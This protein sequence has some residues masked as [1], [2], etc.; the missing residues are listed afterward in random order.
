MP[1]YK[2]L[3]PVTFTGT[4][5]IQVPDNFAG[6]CHVNMSEPPSPVEQG[7][8]SVNMSGAPAGAS[9]TLR[10]DANVVVMTGTESTSPS[11]I[12]LGTYTLTWED[13]A[14]AYSPPGTETHTFVDDTPY[15]FGPP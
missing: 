2:V 15:T 6:N 7:V 4:L 3:V 8:V 11:P 9:W 5:S 13:T 14:F 1:S 12:P 10:N